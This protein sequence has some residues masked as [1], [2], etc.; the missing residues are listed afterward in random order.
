MKKAVKMILAVLVFMITLTACSNVD[1]T[2]NNSTTPEPEPDNKLVLEIKADE[3]GGVDENAY[4]NLNKQ[5]RLFS[6]NLLLNVPYD[7]SKNILYS[8][9]NIYLA[10][11]MLTDIASNETKAELLN[12]L[13]FETSDELDQQIN[14]LW[15]VLNIKQE[16]SLIKLANSIWLSDQFKYNKDPLNHLALKQHVQSYTG[17]MGDP[18]YNRQLQDWINENTENFLKD[19]IKDLGFTA[20]TI[21]SLVSTIYLKDSWSSE[22]H[23]ESTIKDTFHANGKDQEC[24]MMID[25]STSSLYFG[26]KFTAYCRYLRNSKMWFV[27]PNEGVSVQDLIND[28]EVYKFLTNP[29]SFESK[30]GIIEVHIPK[31]D[32]SSNASI[33]DILANMGLH[34]VFDPSKA[35]FRDLVEGMDSLYVDEIKHGA[36]LKIDEEG[37]EAAAYTMID[38][39]ATSIAEY[40]RFS[41]IVDRP[42]I[43]SLNSR[44][45]VNLFTGVVNT[46]K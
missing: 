13:G 28:E 45:G 24:E 18:A 30:R 25:Y 4:L 27:L 32:I 11:S 16:G 12:F 5:I 9:A 46:L 7:E 6:N 26:E 22:F 29:E 23:K 41:F 15:K 20:D 42:F 19:Q 39:K 40:E 33:K 14:E 21:M 2:N 43:F 3:V 35:D 38:V 37:V 10:M 34:L 36:R 1:T 8:P 17:K 31:F 44:D